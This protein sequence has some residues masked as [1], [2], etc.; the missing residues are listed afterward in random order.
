MKESERK[1]RKMKKDIMQVLTI[2]EMATAE[3]TRR[4][5]RYVSVLKKVG[6]KRMKEAGYKMGD[7]DVL[8]KLVYEDDLDFVGLSLPRCDEYFDLC[9]SQ[10][11]VKFMKLQVKI[12]VE[13]VIKEWEKEVEDGN[14]NRS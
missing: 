1:M 10:E 11:R 2:F 7:I 3:R 9:E 12:L 13:K 5:D 14:Q 4:M 8:E 6:P